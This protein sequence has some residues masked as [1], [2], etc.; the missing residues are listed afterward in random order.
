LRLSKRVLCAG[1]GA[2]PEG[3]N[4]FAGVKHLQVTAKASAFA[5]Q[6]PV[7]WVLLQRYFTV[8]CP[9]PGNGISAPS[10]PRDDEGWLCAQGVEKAERGL[11][12]E[13][14]SAAAD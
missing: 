2:V 11:T 1:T 8:Y 5:V 12:I 14:I 9:S 10:S 3:Y 13:E 6:F 7:G 4:N